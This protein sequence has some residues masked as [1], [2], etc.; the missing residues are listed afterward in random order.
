MRNPA[1]HDNFLRDRFANF[2]TTRGQG[3][4][5]GRMI[6]FTYTRL[7]QTIVLAVAYDEV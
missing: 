7:A 3:C 2:F 6:T 5:G 4:G 1:N